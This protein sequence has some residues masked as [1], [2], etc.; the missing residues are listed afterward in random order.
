[1]EKWTVR[2]VNGKNRM[3]VRT[4]ISVKIMTVNLSL[5]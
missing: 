5:E 3:S 1:M 4:M 2:F